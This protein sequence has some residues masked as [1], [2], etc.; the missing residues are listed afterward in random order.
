VVRGGTIWW[1]GILRRGALIAAMEGVTVE[2]VVDVDVTEPAVC[3]C[4]MGMMPIFDDR[5]G[6]RARSDGV[7]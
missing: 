6:T 4:V 5:T 3:L 1:V 7:V 2:D